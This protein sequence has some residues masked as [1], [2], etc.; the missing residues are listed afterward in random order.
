MEAAYTVVDAVANNAESGTHATDVEAAGAALASVGIVP[1]APSQAPGVA[2]ALVSLQVQEVSPCTGTDIG[3]GTLSTYIEPQGFCCR[4]Q[5]R[6]AKTLEEGKLGLR[7]LFLGI[8]PWDSSQALGVAA[9]LVSLQVL[10]G[11]LDLAEECGWNKLGDMR[12][13]GRAETVLAWS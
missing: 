4:R 12:G 7:L 9:A 1:W 11:R 5:Q 2:A 6:S 8:I 3:A 13:K 10:W